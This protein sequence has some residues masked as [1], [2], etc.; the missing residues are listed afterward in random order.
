[1]LNLEDWID[2]VDVAGACLYG[3]EWGSV[4][5][6]LVTSEATYYY[7]NRESLDA[8]ECAKHIYEEA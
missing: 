2:S 3:F 7:Y 6:E 1:M 8:N 4:P 5:E